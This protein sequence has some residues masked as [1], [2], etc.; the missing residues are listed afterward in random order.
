MKIA[1]FTRFCYTEKLDKSRLKLM[2]NNFIA[3]LKNQTFKDFDIFVI[4][5]EHLGNIGHPENLELIQNLDFGDLNVYFDGIEKFKYD[6][7]IRLDSD[8]E[9]VSTFIEFIKK[10][11]EREE[12]VLINFKPIKRYKGVN[13]RHERD[14]NE[15]CTSMFLALVQRGEK[16]KCVH[17]RPH[18]MMGKHIGKVITINEGYVYLKIHDF[19]MT[20]KFL[21][22]EIR[23]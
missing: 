10:I 19:N 13:Y 5:K 14:Y 20:S 4:C 12:N 8:D 7:E 11:A 23:H 3:S 1:V 15:H 2:Q 18:G 16:T 17:D 21:G 9:V 6:V 22:N